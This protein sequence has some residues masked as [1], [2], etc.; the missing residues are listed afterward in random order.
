VLQQL[1]HMLPRTVSN[2]S[3]PTSYAEFIALR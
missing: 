3:L 1:A 2:L